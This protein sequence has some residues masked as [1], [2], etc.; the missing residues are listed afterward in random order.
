MLAAKL[1][2]LL[3]LLIVESKEFIPEVTER[4]REREREKELKAECSQN[5]RIFSGLSKERRIFFFV[6]SSLLDLPCALSLSPKTCNVRELFPND[7]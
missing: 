3:L 7:S 1:P 6:F 4:E 5:E 2:L